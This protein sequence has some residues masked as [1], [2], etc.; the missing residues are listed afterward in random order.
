MCLDV[1]ANG[2]GGSISRRAKGAPGRRVRGTGG[3]VGVSGCEALSIHTTHFQAG[4]MAHLEG[5][6]ALHVGF[7]KHLFLCFFVFFCV[8]LFFFVP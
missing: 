5:F 1:R 2:A 3:E 6:F 7:H 8:F 4:Q